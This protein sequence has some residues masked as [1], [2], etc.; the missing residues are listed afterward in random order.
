MSGKKPLRCFNDR[1][2]PANNSRLQASALAV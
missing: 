1:R 2:T